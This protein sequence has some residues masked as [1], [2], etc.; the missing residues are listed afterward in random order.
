VCHYMK[1]FLFLSQ[2]LMTSLKR[3]VMHSFPHLEIV[4][5][6]KSDWIYFVAF[7]YYFFSLRRLGRRRRRMFAFFS[8]FQRACMCIRTLEHIY[9]YLCGCVH[10]HKHKIAL[11]L[12]TFTFTIYCKFFLFFRLYLFTC[13][14]YSHWVPT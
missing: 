13:F 6:K 2:F 4:Y 5:R 10:V 11:F 3:P 12:I 8:F 7:F 1:C 14:K 9:I